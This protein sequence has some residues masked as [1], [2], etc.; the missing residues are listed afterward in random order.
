M[1]CKFLSC[2]FHPIAHP[3]IQ[4]FVKTA[5]TFQLKSFLHPTGWKA[6]REG[7]RQTT[8]QKTIG[9]ELMDAAT[10]KQKAYIRKLFI[11]CGVPKWMF[12][13]L[14]L[15]N[16]SKEDADMLI[17]GLRIMKKF[18]HGDLKDVIWE[19]IQGKNAIQP[20]AKTV[21]QLEEET[22]DPD[23]GEWLERVQWENTDPPDGRKKH[24]S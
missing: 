6:L 11:K 2:R 24:C 16:I 7:S 15:W 21:D 10:E 18:D 22:L 4:F 13:P 17:N 5:F 19:T 3:I 9:G 12:N 1:F 20:Q 14:K 8:S 23:Q